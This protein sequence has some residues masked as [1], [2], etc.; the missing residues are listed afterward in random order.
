MSARKILLIDD[1]PDILDVLDLI[2]SENYEIVQASN[3][4]EALKI[5]KSMMEAQLL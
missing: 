4:Q 1:D 2:L 3:G 5:L